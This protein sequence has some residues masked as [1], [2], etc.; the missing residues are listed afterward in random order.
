MDGMDVVEGS[1]LVA[2]IAAKH[3]RSAQPES[4]QLCAVLAAIVE[5]L[6]ER[7]LKDDPTA[8]FL[9]SLTPLKQPETLQNPEVL[10]IL[11]SMH[12]LPGFSML[13]ACARTKNCIFFKFYGSS[14]EIV[15]YYK[16]YLCLQMHNF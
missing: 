11:Y 7:G 14:L 8:I 13:L 10:F 1:N 9:G 5:G 6:R 2:D 3:R 4:V 16:P 15:F 12:D